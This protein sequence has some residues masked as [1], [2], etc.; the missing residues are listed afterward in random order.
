MSTLITWLKI[1]LD[2]LF[3]HEKRFDFKLEMTAY[4]RRSERKQALLYP[5]RN[6]GSTLVLLILSDLKD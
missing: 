5:S 1:S 4:E 2:A 3:K 6:F